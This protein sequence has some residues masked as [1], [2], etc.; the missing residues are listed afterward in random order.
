MSPKPT[1]VLVDYDKKRNERHAQAL[2]AAGVKAVRAAGGSEAFELCRGAPPLAVVAE[3]MIPDGNGFELLRQLKT[4]PATAAV[5][6]ILAVDENDS[7]TLSR[8]QIS[9]LDGIL[10]RPFTPEALVARV[11]SLAAEETRPSGRPAATPLELR[12]LLDAL[13]TRAR[14]ENPLLPHLTDP[15][16]GLWNVGY[17]NL[18]LAEEF[19]KARRFSLPLACLVMGLDEAPGEVP[20]DEGTN[21]QVLTE[22]A[23]LLL[24]ESR[25]I[26]HLARL[27]A[28]TFLLLLPHTDGAGALAMTNR[29]LTA[30]EQ[31]QLTLP[32]RTRPVTASVGIACF[33]KDLGGPDDLVRAAHDALARAVALGGN[34]VE[35]RDPE[36]AAR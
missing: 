23:G 8:A 6:V 3:A 25:D 19:K 15:V 30:I 20:A 31:R 29:V 2:A 17:T 21:R 18:K 10:V 33:S 13:E 35:I 24:C 7:Y 14:D 32:G 27:D 12:P 22:L 4:D 28:G 16:T 34:R 11:K 26:D 5:K 1:I 9:G 36:R